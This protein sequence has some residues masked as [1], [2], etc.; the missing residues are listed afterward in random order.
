MDLSALLGSMSAGPPPG[1]SVQDEYKKPSGLMSL[2][3]YQSLQQKEQ[4]AEPPVRSDELYDEISPGYMTDE[5]QKWQYKNED[6]F[7]FVGANISSLFDAISQLAQILPT[8]NKNNVASNSKNNAE[9][10]HKKAIVKSKKF[11]NKVGEFIDADYEEALIDSVGFR[12][13]SG[14]ILKPEAELDDISSMREILAE[15][16]KY[17]GHQVI[18]KITPFGL[19]KMTRIL[20]KYRKSDNQW[21][22]V[23]TT[24]ELIYKYLSLGRIT[25]NDFFQ[26][27][28]ELPVEALLELEE[29][30]NT[31]HIFMTP[32]EMVTFRNELEYYK[33]NYNGDGMQA[34]VNKAIAAVT[35]LRKNTVPEPI[36]F[37]PIPSAANNKPVT[38]NNKTINNKSNNRPIDEFVN[39]NNAVKELLS[40]N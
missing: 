9:T 3:D 34:D 12:N 37:V 22:R 6:G 17:N 35:N 23:A 16:K 2:E 19:L 13:D 18:R 11:Y 25:R 15:A 36:P 10:R 40:N 28:N 4:P 30:Y 14:L 39:N 8:E 29:F 7:Y 20:S 31:D 32:T 21:I 24:C 27:Q 26:S 38:I 33:Y 5:S 1:P